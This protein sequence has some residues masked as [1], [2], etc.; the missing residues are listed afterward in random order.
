VHDI[1]PFMI[2]RLKLQADL[3]KLKHKLHT[4]ATGIP[5]PQRPHAPLAYYEPHEVL[6][7]R[8]LAMVCMLIL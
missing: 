6:D 2:L 8:A 7:A 4:A 1:T 3:Q 5:I